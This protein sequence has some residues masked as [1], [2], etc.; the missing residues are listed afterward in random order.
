VKSVGCI[1][2]LAPFRRAFGCLR[3]ASHTVPFRGLG[4]V[5]L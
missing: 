3:N 1:F 4:R 5:P 2:A